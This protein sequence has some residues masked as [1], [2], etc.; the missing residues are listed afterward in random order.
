MQ[1]TP[2][3]GSFTTIDDEKTIQTYMWDGSEWI[4]KS[5]DVKSPALSG[6]YNTVS[7]K[8]KALPTVQSTTKPKVKTVTPTKKVVVETIVIGGQT[9]EITKDISGTMATDSNAENVINE[10]I[11]T[12]YPGYEGCIK[13]VIGTWSDGVTVIY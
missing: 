8:K 11:V 4:L 10:P 6:I 12:V 1:T 7:N 13:K 3:L 2:T 9:I 5:E